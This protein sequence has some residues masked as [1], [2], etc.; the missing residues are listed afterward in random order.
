MK[1]IVDELL[2]LGSF[3]LNTTGLAVEKFWE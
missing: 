1:S 2:T 3:T